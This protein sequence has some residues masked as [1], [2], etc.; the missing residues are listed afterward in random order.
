MIMHASDRSLEV[1]FACCLGQRD[2]GTAAYQQH[3]GHQ[4]DGDAGVG[5]NEESKQ[6]CAKNGTN[7][8]REEVD[9]H[10]GGPAEKGRGRES[11]SVR[12]V[13]KTRP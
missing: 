6:V 4:E 3:T 5:M 13:L 12:G 9:S 2:G 11:C 7:P 1:S 8:S 10:G